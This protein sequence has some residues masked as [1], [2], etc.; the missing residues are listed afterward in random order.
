MLPWHQPNWEGFARS[1]GN[2]H[3]AQLVVA[4]EGFGLRE[5]C[6]DMARFSLCRHPDGDRGA[7]CGECQNCKLFIAGTHPDLHVVS[8]EWE[9]VNGRA[10]AIARYSEMYQD[11]EGREKKA[12]PARIIPIDQIRILIDNFAR[13]P[14]ISQR[15]VGLIVPA[16][17]LNINAANALLKLLEEPPPDSLLILATSEPSRLPRTV[18]SRCIRLNLS[19]S[20]REQALEWLG[21]HVETGEMEMA[22]ELAD[23]A[24]LKARTLC[25]TGLMQARKDMVEGLVGISRRNLSPYEL[26]ASLQRLEFEEVLKWLQEFVKDLIKWKGAGQMPWWQAARDTGP[27][28]ETLSQDKLFQVYD[29]IS[30]YRRIARGNLNE[31]LAL[32]NILLSIQQAICS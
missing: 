2:L 31:E 26:S 21:Q 10:D 19:K 8:T 13:R 7:G 32:D 3:H 30:A 12:R 18:L 22:L 28:P 20:D 15:K 9:A 11:R 1:F 17:R 24:P 16:D 27:A 25:E 6:L 4:P 29:R 14:H 5:F 23:G